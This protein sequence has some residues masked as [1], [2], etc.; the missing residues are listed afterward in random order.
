[1]QDDQEDYLRPQLGIVAL[2][3]GA[4]VLFS[5]KQSKVCFAHSNLDEA[6]SDISVA[7]SEIYALG[8]GVAE[9]MG[10]SYVVEE[11]GL[12]SIELPMNIQVDNKTAQ[13]FANGTV[14]RSKI[15]HIDQRQM[16]VRAMRNGK[17]VNV[18]HVSTKFNLADIMTKPLLRPDFTRIRSTLML[19]CPTN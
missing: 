13:F 12:P 5:S 15:R 14:K 8:S 17:I 19:T 6:H 4:P 1:M 2:C 18:S 10:L 16:F 3:G 9:F 11:L 7:A